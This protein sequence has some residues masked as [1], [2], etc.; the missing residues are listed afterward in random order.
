MAQCPGSKWTPV[1]NTLKEPSAHRE[2]NSFRKENCLLAGQY[3]PFPT[4]RFN[5]LF[6]GYPSEL[7]FRYTP[8]CAHTLSFCLHFHMIDKSLYTHVNST[9]TPDW[10]CAHIDVYIFIR[11]TRHAFTHVHTAYLHTPT[12]YLCISMHTPTLAHTCAE[13]YSYLQI[14]VDKQTAIARKVLERKT[15]TNWLDSPGGGIFFSHTS[16]TLFR[17]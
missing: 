10:P 5:L 1:W 14:P 8:V 2:M 15:C 12:T 13:P 11:I 17:I 7:G 4:I 16:I 3:S 9:P 6:Q